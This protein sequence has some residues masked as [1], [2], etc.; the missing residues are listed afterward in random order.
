MDGSY[1]TSYTNVSFG[2]IDENGK[3]EL[4]WSDEFYDGYKIRVNGDCL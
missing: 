4:T 2:E 3:I 1:Y